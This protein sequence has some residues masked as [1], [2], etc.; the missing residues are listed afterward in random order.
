[1]TVPSVSLL[2]GFMGDPSDWDAVIPRLA[3]Y[4]VTTPLIRP[5]ASWD[6][7][8]EQLAHEL[9][10]QS[11]FVGY[12]MGARLLLAVAVAYPARCLGLVFVSG[13]PGLENDMARQAR[14]RQDAQIADRIDREPRAAFLNWWYTESRVFRSLTDEVRARE[15]DRKLARSADD[16]PAILRTYSVS[17]QPDLWAGL[18]ALPFPVLAVAGSLDRKYANLMERMGTYPNISTRI[19]PNCGHIVHHEQPAVFQEL[20][21]QYLRSNFAVT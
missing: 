4:R 13:H 14:W 18:K 2:H 20:L 1:M 8:I 3:G 12:S 6:A 9:P 15:I 10:E 19:I 7:G 5:A 17:K 11:V 16:W 21:Q